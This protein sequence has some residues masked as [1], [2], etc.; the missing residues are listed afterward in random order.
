MYP[1]TLSNVSP[2]FTWGEVSQ[3]THPDGSELKYTYDC[4]GRI[5]KIETRPD[6]TA[7]W[8]KASEDTYTAGGE[9]FCKITYDSKGDSH[10][11][12]FLGGY[13][14][15]QTQAGFLRL[16]WAISGPNGLVMWKQ[17][18]TNVMCYLDKTKKNRDSHLFTGVEVGARVSACRE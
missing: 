5:A 10:E 2:E 16:R 9:R 15:E 8:S 3:E 1:I 13:E 12:L 17:Y 14:L 6:D 11:H 4:W 7:S 18:A